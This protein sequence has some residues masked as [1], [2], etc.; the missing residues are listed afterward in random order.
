MAAGHDAV[1]SHRSAA[2]LWG[3]IDHPPA[4][5][6]IT[7]PERW[8]RKLNGVTIHRAPDLSESCTLLHNGIYVTNPLR[9]L[10]DMAASADLATLS[11]AVDRGVGRKLFAPPAVAAELDRRAQRGRP[12][13]VNF[14]AAL[15]ER[16]V[17]G[18]PRPS[19]LERMMHD[20]MERYN[21]PKAD[22][23]VKAGPDGEYRVD[24][25]YVPIK[26]SIEVDGYVWHFTPE[27]QQRDAERRNKLVI[28]GWTHFTYTFLDAVRRP[29]GIAGEIIAMHQRLTE[30]LSGEGD[31]G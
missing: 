25:A 28:D 24:M 15:T 14:R 18:A 30:Q 11:A 10:A 29:P 31:L 23:E 9:A 21:V 2:Y 27:H 26:F 22:I 19:V 3:L 8:V 6:E 4:E 13:I 12:G 20:I 17:I 1:A 16:G 5:P 7:V